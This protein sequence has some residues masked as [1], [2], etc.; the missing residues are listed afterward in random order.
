M[1][2]SEAITSPRQAA[3]VL[4]NLMT[5]Q[6]RQQENRKFEFSD[7]EG[8]VVDLAD[9]KASIRSQEELVAYFEAIA[10]PSIKTQAAFGQAL[11][12]AAQKNYQRGRNID[13]DGGR[14][15]QYRIK[16]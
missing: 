10:N 8:H 11:R 12:N 4:M 14:K 3:R 7:K 5:G 2:V 6:S 15:G 9:V 13:G 16:R 1:S